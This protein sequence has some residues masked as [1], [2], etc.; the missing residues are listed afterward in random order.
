M[1]FEKRLREHHTVFR[2]LTWLK[3]LAIRVALFGYHKYLIRRYLASSPIR[4]LQVGTGY[5]PLRGWLN[6]DLNPHVRVP[7]LDVIKRF[8][9]PSGVFDYVYSEHLIEHFAYPEGTAFLRE[10]F[11][12]LKA[13][14][15]IRIATPDLHFLIDLYL[16]GQSKT[17]VDYMQKAIAERGIHSTY[18]NAFIV[19]DFFQNWG[20]KF[21]YDS[22]TLGEQLRD[23]GFVNVQKESVGSSHDRELVNIE[24]HGKR[25]G[26]DANRLQTMVLTAQKPFR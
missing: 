12:V 5:T 20:H 21:I 18:P 24:Q 22:N 26:D 13:G 9:L 23:A 1:Q 17:Q 25:I 7:Y 10:S 2:L 6:T 4:K 3:R 14:G 8:P 16:N 15:K 11:R 19:N